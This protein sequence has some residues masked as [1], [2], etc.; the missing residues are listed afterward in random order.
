MFEQAFNLT[1]PRLRPSGFGGQKG[2]EAAEEMLPFSLAQ[3]LRSA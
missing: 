2:A 1:L 3:G